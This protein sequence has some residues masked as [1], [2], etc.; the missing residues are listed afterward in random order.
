MRGKCQHPQKVN[1]FIY[2]SDFIDK[3]LH[4]CRSLQEINKTI[5][6]KSLVLKMKDDV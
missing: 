5:N 4:G 1:E 3:Y 2:E 6:I